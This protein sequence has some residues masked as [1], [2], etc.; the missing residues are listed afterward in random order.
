M[1]WISVT[2]RLP[3]AY[4]C[5]LVWAP[6]SFPKNTKCVVAEFYDDN[7][8]FYSED[9]SIMRDVTHWMPLPQAPTDAPEAPVVVGEVSTYAR[10]SFDRSDLNKLLNLHWVGSEAACEY[11]EETNTIDRI[12]HPDMEKLVAAQYRLCQNFSI[13]VAADL[14][15]DGTLQNYRVHR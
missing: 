13:N 14:M 15:S 7:G 1:N 11:N 9:G 8:L 3:D 5:Y 4:G 10:G 2:K 12:D 6:E